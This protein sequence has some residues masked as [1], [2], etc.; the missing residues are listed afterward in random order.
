M[1]IAQSTKSRRHKTASNPFL[2]AKPKRA[3]AGSGS[4]Q[5]RLPR[6]PFLVDTR[7]VPISEAQRQPPSCLWVLRMTV[8][9]CGEAASRAEDPFA[10]RKSRKRR[11]SPLA[12]ECLQWADAVEQSFICCSCTELLGRS[13]RSSGAAAKSEADQ[14]EF[15]L[16]TAREGCNALDYFT[17]ALLGKL[18]VRS[19]WPF[20]LGQ[21]SRTGAVGLHFSCG[22]GEVAALQLKETHNA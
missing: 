11:L 14:N 12:C 20:D 3:P 21:R 16:C 9:G 19:Y 6:S 1:A 5:E 7:G 4:S 15:L 22:F 10:A 2:R 13:T 8:G 18:A 17:G